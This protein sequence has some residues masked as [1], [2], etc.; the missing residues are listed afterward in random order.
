M[1]AMRRTACGRW[2]AVNMISNAP[3]NGAQ[4]ITDS[5]GNPIV[6]RARSVRAVRRGQR[7]EGAGSSPELGPHEEE[8]HAEGDAIDVILRLAALHSA[9]HVATAQRPRAQDVE[10]A[11]DD[12]S[13]DPADESGEAQDE[14]PVQ[15]RVE[16]V[17]AVAPACQVV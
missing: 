12:V 14:G 15:T 13:I 8:E 4:V 10:H 16:R 1:A 11:V 9:K 6:T 5:T 17:E 7:R 3:T 2:R